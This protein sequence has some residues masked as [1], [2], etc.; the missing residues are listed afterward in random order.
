MR[1]QMLHERMFINGAWERREETFEVYDPANGNCIALVPKASKEDVEGAIRSAKIGAT[2]SNDLPVH[3]RYTILMDTVAYLQDH[4]EL[5][6]ETIV[7]ESSKTIREAKR[8]VSRCMETIRISAEE[9]KRITGETIPFSQM[10]NHIGRVGYVTR[11]PVGIVAAITPFNDPLNLVAHKV[12]PAIA[13]GNAVILKPSSETPLSAIRLVEAFLEAGLPK[14]ILSVITGSGREIGDTLVSSE[15]VRFI[16]FTGGYHTGEAI[17]KKAGV[18][19]IAMELGSNAPT[20]VLADA[21]LEEAVQSTVSGAF[22][23]AGQNCIGVQRLYVEEP[24]F[25]TF[26]NRFVSETKKLTVGD[27]RDIC[28]DVGPMISEKEAKRVESWILEACANGATLHCGGRRQG[29]FITPAVLTNVSQ[30]E[31][32]MKEE[33]FGPTATITSVASLDE[34]IRLANDSC[35]GLQ[36]GIFT[37]SMNAAFSAI[38][39]LDVGGVMVNDSSD[40]RIDAMPFGG[41]KRSGLGR[42]GIKSA[43][44]AMT[45]EKVVAFNLKK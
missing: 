1:G 38:D 15:D 11:V 16:S 26:T 14:E 17:T 19:K 29:A 20:I 31:K 40:V 35:Y 12:A 30:Q 43:I 44:L 24:V 5:F 9:A 4:T 7:M 8:E 37:T 25:E 23:V 18:K 32:L 42:E 22:G 21:D 2:I 33:V 34:A 13:S 45:E 28:T 10:P 39:K 6:V 3:Q 41:V 27:K 36:A